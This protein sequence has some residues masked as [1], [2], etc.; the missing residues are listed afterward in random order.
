LPASPSI[1]MPGVPVTDRGREKVNVS[2]SDFRSGSGN[3]LR[4]PGLKGGYVLY[5]DAKGR[6]QI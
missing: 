2:F 4:D 5:R 1:G 3:Q 6:L